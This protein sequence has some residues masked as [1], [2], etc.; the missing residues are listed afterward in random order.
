MDWD[1][2]EQVEFRTYYNVTYNGHVITYSLYEE[3][4]S[5]YKDSDQL[6]CLS[7][8][9]DPNAPFTQFCMVSYQ[10]LVLM[11]IFTSYDPHCNSCN[12]S[13]AYATID[14]SYPAQCED[15]DFVAAYIYYSLP[16]LEGALNCFVIRKLYQSVG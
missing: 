12:E 3:Y 11:P 1:D 14:S 9:E 5:R 8:E 13:T 4:D 10:G 2:I 7:N 16:P 6:L 15:F